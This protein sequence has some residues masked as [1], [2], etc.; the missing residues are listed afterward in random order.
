MLSNV[1]MH[2][3]AQSAINTSISARLKPTA[4]ASEQWQSFHITIIKLY[5]NSVRKA[6][7]DPSVW[8]LKNTV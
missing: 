3:K 6:V 5:C 8:F 1:L 4:K 7:H 2:L